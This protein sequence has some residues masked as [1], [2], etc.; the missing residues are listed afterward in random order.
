MSEWSRFLVDVSEPVAGLAV[1]AILLMAALLTGLAFYAFTI[2]LNDRT[3]NRMKILERDAE[4]MIAGGEPLEA[5]KLVITRIESFNPNSISHT[6]LSAAY[7]WAAR[8]FDQARVSIP[9]YICAVVARMYVPPPRENFAGQGEEP[10]R[11]DMRNTAQS[12]EELCI[13]KVE[14]SSA[15]YLA[16]QL[17]EAWTPETHFAK[18]ILERYLP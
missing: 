15:R 8:G 2:F 12:L 9:A 17:Q 13:A 3:A 7:I 5:A 4:E 6:E 16:D 1:P 10:R 18:P 14:V 11:K